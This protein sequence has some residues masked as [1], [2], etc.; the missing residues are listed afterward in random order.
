MS[1]IQ[2]DE[3]QQQYT[4]RRILGERVQPGMVNFLMA[5]GIVKS[6]RQAGHILVIIAT[7][8]FVLSLYLFANLFGWFDSADEYIPTEA[9]LMQ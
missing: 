4:S 3:E 9:E 7:V 6:Q 2:F 5:K 8:C 1:T